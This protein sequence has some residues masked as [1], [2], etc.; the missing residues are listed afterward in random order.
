MS[1]VYVK[2]VST[3]IHPVEFP[4]KNQFPKKPGFPLS[5]LIILDPSKV[6]LFLF[7]K[8]SGKIESW[9]REFAWQSQSVLPPLE[10]GRN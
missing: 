9:S 4:Q 7:K 10:I 3:P 2:Y 6:D 8:E 5:A 1:A